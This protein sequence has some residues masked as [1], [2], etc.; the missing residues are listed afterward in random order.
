MSTKTKETSE[1]QA[2]DID[3]ALIDPDP[4]NRKEHDKAS[5]QSLADSIAADGL[6]QPI[7]VRFH[8]QKPGRYMIEAGERRWR[9][10]Q[11]LKETFI[12]AL[13]VKSETEV[14]AARKRAVE[15]F[16]REDLTPIEE[17]RMFRELVEDHKLTQGEVAKL[18]NRQNPSY[19]SNS[20]RLLECPGDVQ[21]LIQEGNLTRAHGVALARWARW[22]KLCLSIANWSVKKGLSSKSLEDSDLPVAYELVR[23]GLVAEITS[24]EYKLP[25]VFKDDPDFIAQGYGSGWYCLS[26]SKWAPEKALQD[27]IRAEKAA[28]DSPGE[29][30]SAASTEKAAAERRA[31]IDRNKKRRE[32]LRAERDR[33]FKVLVRTKTVTAHEVAILVGEAIS[34][35]YHSGRLREVASSLGLKVPAGVIGGQGLRNLKALAKMDPMDLAR[36]AVG[37]ILHKQVDDACKNGASYTPVALN[38]YAKG[39]RK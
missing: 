16:Q 14:G 10:V 2:I 19:V 27:K 6:M 34:G 28:K 13:L 17:A 12:R 24:W 32:T 9:A 31:V 18:A 20:L 30:K 26:P 8:P 36:L 33:V 22:P 37:V 1:M 21:K 23:E 38:L 39:G 7:V 15:N 5:L 29:K 11:L 3:I 35:V 25:P 4:K